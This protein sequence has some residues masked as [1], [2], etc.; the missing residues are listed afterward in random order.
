[1]ESSPTAG[2]DGTGKGFRV[3]ISS[4]V[5]INLRCAIVT[6][7]SNGVRYCVEK[8]LENEQGKTC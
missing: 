3:Q 5:T 4:Y 6:S 7:Q 2:D 8:F 1:M